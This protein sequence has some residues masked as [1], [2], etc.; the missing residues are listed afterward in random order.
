MIRETVSV[1]ITST[2]SAPS[3]IRPWA[4]T[5]PYTKPEHAALTSN[6]PQRRPSS[7]CTEAALPHCWSG[8]V[9]ASTR[10]ST[11][12]GESPAIASA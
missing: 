5:S 9:V 1:P 4:V 11:R 3:A 8:V 12:S 2:R 6:D 7:C 10:A